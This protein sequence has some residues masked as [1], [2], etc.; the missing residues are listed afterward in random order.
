MK[1]L[2]FLFGL[3]VM[4]L[5]HSTAFAQEQEPKKDEKEPPKKA[6]VKIEKMESHKIK[7]N[8]RNDE[9]VRK[10]KST[11]RAENKK[12][13]KEQKEQRKKYEDRRVDEQHGAVTRKM[14]RDERKANKF[15]ETRS[16]TLSQSSK[17]ANK[18]HFSL[19]WIFHRNNQKPGIN[20]A[21]ARDADKF[22]ASHGATSQSARDA[23]KVHF[24]LGWLFNRDKSK[25]DISSRSQRRANRNNSSK[26]VK[27][28]SARDANKIHLSLGWLFHR[29]GNNAKGGGEHRS[30]KG[31]N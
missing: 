26:S 10:P 24:S 3:F 23:N 22:N 31:T 25:P 12:Q 9:F 1:K 4:V 29:K 6:K 18:I 5:C 14:K 21:S 8:F 19:G 27:S 15:N 30:Y 17:D 11:S 2:L 13:R 16:Q 20:G 7:R 28:Q